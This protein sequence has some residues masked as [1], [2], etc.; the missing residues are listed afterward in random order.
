MTDNLT[1]KTLVR[2]AYDI[3]QLRIQMGNRIVANFKAKLGQQPSEK[4]ETLEEDEQRLLNIIRLSFDKIMD[5]L[6]HLPTPKRFKGDEVI[7]TYT[8]LSLMEQYVSLEKQ[9]ASHFRR[10]QYALQE[11]PIYT[12]FLAEVNGCGT[13]MS[14]V[15]ISEID[16]S[17]AEY[18]SS[19]WKYAG[20]DVANDGKGRSRRKEH[21]QETEYIDK[22]GNQAKKMGITF[23]PFLKT[24]LMGV[25]SASFLRQGKE[26]QYAKHYYNYKNRL[27]QHL[28]HQDKTKLHKH[29]MAMRFMIKRFLVDL[30]I[31][32]RKLEGLPVATE[33]SEGK[34]G[35]THKKAA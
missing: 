23:N 28:D 34:L 4:E 26:N 27:E 3:Q 35:M 6:K 2:G 5:G 12:N 30:Y 32:W 15:I 22:E 7:S 19:L 33:Y 16:I 18:P 20:L 13:A 1:I 21:L 14:A 29:N 31:E 24:K 11:Y 10:L 8:E 25:L 9:E 17:K